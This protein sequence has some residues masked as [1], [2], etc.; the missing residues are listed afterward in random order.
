[1][2]LRGSVTCVRCSSYPIEKEK[3]SF[4]GKSSWKLVKLDIGGALDDL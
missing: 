3:G 2:A 1:M 4:Y